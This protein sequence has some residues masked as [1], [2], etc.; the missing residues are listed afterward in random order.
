MVI[1]FGEVREFKGLDVCV[2]L[3]GNFFLTFFT[4]SYKDTGYF[5]C[6]VA[7]FLITILFSWQTDIIG[8][9]FNSS[10]THLLDNAHLITCS[11]I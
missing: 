10:F 7:L 4:I 9:H 6:S 8:I 1:R 2:F 11:A 5:P 3:E